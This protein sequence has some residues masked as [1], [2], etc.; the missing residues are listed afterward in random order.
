[1]RSSRRCGLLRTEPGTLQSPLLYCGTAPGDSSPLATV[2]LKQTTAPLL[3]MVLATGYWCLGVDVERAQYTW[4]LSNSWNETLTL[5]RH[6]LNIYMTMENKH[7]VFF[8][9]H[10]GSPPWE[11]FEGQSRSQCSNPGT[12]LT[13]VCLSLV[14]CGGCTTCLGIHRIDMTIVH[15]CNHDK[16]WGRYTT[17]LHSVVN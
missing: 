16:R 14:S 9:R 17:A 4:V 2:Y 5:R 15:G 13:F 10:Y 11:V 7:T 6:I 8:L 1:L 3:D 12:F